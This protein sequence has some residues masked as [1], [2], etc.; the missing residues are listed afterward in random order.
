MLLN[1]PGTPIWGGATPGPSTV[2]A[3]VETGLYSAGARLALAARCVA[4]LALLVG[5]PNPVLGQAWTQPAGNTY[6]KISSQSATASQQF[7]ADGTRGPYTPD[8][9]GNGFE[10]NSL[11]LYGE[12]GVATNFTLVFLV[13]YKRFTVRTANPLR[14]SGLAGTERPIENSASG[15]EKIQIGVRW[16]STRFFGLSAGGRHRTALNVSVRL[17]A[18]YSRDDSPALGPG[19]VDLEAMVYYGIS[20][21][22]TPAYA[23]IGTGYRVRSGIYALSDGTSGKPAYAN[24]W[25]LHGEAG[26]TLGRWALI[27]GLAFGVFSNQPADLAFNPE[28]PLPTYQR[29]VKL[30]GGLVLYPIPRVGLSVQLFQTVDGANTIRSTDRFFGLEVQ[31]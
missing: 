26:L 13:P 1:Q 17:P 23:Q 20:L 25:L 5:I 2:G 10:D 21:W 18:F 31:F 30:G 8:V 12:T 19:Q 3:G 7:R 6:L 22:P 29:Y 11:Y 27:Q 14:A 15:L 4:A 24:E 16:N 9:D 28:N